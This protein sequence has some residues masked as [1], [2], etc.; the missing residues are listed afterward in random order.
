VSGAQDW[1]QGLKENVIIGRLIPARVEIP[2]MEELLKPE[3]V[4]E[5]A[6]VSPGGWLGLP[7]APTGPF[8]QPPGEEDPVEPNIFTDAGGGQ[9]SVPDQANDED[10]DDDDL[11]DVDDIDED[12]DESDDLTLAESSDLSTNGHSQDGDLN[13]SPAFGEDDAEGSNE[14]DKPTDGEGDE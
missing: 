5:I 7:N 9:D 8:D 13:I 10:V 2:G 12:D 6:A 3:P 14:T 11:D 4:P 1:L